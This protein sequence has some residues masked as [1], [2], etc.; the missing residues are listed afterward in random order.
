MHTVVCST[1]IPIMLRY[2]NNSGG[3]IISKAIASTPKSKPSNILRNQLAPVNEN[4]TM[5][6]PQAV[7]YLTYVQTIPMLRAGICSVDATCRNRSTPK[8]MRLT[9]RRSTG[10]VG[11]RHSGARLAF[12]TIRST[13]IGTPLMHI[14]GPSDSILTYP[15][16][17][18][19]LVH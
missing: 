5:T 9:N 17:G 3:C 18:T 19:T 6:F 12:C 8:P 7:A 11:T 16:S 1:E 10:M 14:H 15:R 13:N 4:L 2:Y